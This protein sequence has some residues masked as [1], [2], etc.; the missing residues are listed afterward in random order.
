MYLLGR[1]QWTLCA[2]GTHL[3]KQFLA[4][5]FELPLPDCP[6]HQLGDN[7]TLILVPEGLIKSL[8]NLIG[9]TEIDSCHDMPL[10]LKTSTTVNISIRQPWSTLMLHGIA[11]EGCPLLTSAI[12]ARQ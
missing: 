3:A 12:S 4:P 6:S 8:L 11:H 1:E 7:R 9:D 10:L 5:N 2:S